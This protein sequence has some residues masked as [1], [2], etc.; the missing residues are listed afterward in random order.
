MS[1]FDLQILDPVTV[2]D[3]VERAAMLGSPGRRDKRIWFSVEERH[4][5]LLSD[6]ADP[7]VLGALRHATRRGRSLHVR[8][9]PTSPSLLANLGELQLAW[10]QWYGTDSVE[11]DSDEVAEG[12]P[13][14]MGALLA[15]SGGVDSAYTLYGHGAGRAGG[16]SAAVM[17][18]GF[19]IPL[20]DVDGFAGASARARRMTDSLGVELVLLSTNVRELNS[21]WPYFH[22]PALASALT[23]LSARSSVGLIAASGSYFP[24]TVP[25]GS[26]PVSD[27]LLG[28]ESFA[29]RHHGAGATRTE[30]LQA[31]A[32]WPEAMDS[33]RVCW[34]G[35]R[36]DR[37]CGTCRKCVTLALMC[38]SLG[39]EPRFF[40]G[41]ISERAIMTMV[42]RAPGDDFS[43]EYRRLTLEAATRRG[44]DEPWVRSIRWTL[45]RHRLRCAWR[46]LRGLGGR[47]ARDTSGRLGIVN[48]HPELRAPLRR[49]LRKGHRTMRRSMHRLRSSVSPPWRR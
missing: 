5:A 19:D 26:N 15:F 34:S 49:R 46:E 13:S 39:I 18:H 24:L 47:P 30:K 37:N 21:P 10:R 43:A 29:I 36:N 6:R 44:I 17:V 4:R 35:P 23:L 20:D 16:R 12:A 40:D 45:R 42:R 38:R 1:R 3:R 22:G 48:R 14:D 27:P 7:F 32:S 8:G 11:L 28:S 25:W 41:P 9:A 33:L 31:L 2:D